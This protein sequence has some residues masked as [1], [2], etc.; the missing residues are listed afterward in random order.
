MGAL[1]V[2]RLMLLKKKQKVN[3]LSCISAAKNYAFNRI[4]IFADSIAFQT[5]AEKKDGHIE[6][7]FRVKKRLLTYFCRAPSW[8]KKKTTATWHACLSE[9]KSACRVSYTRPY[10]Q[11]SYQYS[12][13]K[14]DIHVQIQNRDYRTAPDLRGP[15]KHIYHISLNKRRGR[16]FT[17]LASWFGVYW[18]QV[19]ICKMPVIM[20]FAA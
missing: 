9:R 10:W 2:V 17:K 11:H 6:I 3:C 13:G 7:A 12:E 14:P 4:K 18:R 19:F 1:L 15:G 20:V 5:R 16:L 8:F